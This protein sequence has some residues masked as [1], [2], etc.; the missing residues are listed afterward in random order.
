MDAGSDATPEVPP[1]GKHQSNEADNAIKRIR[2]QTRVLKD[3]LRAMCQVKLKMGDVIA[4]WLITH[5]AATI[6]RYAVGEDRRFAY[7]MVRGRRFM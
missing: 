4:P 2:S 7:E 1:G 6:N 3:A 5:A